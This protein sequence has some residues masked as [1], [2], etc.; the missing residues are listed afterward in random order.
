MRERTIRPRGPR[1]RE[2]VGGKIPAYDESLLHAGKRPADTPQERARRGRRGLL[3]L[4]PDE[5]NRSGTFHLLT[6]TLPPPRRVI[7]L[8]QRC[9]K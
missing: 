9:R 6:E 5:I 8:I 2:S 1:G 7:R 4:S 3:S